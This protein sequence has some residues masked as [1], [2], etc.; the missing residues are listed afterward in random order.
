MRKTLLVLLAL[1]VVGA[2]PA[3]SAHADSPGQEVAYGAG[4]VFGT[5]LYAPFKTTFCVVGA[6]TSGLA[7]PFSGPHGSARMVTAA[8]AGTWAITPAVLKGQQ[9]VRFAGEPRPATFEPRST[10]LEPWP[11]TSEPQPTTSELQPA[12]SE[13]RPAT[14][15]P[16]PIT[17]EP[18]P[19]TSEPRS[20]IKDWHDVDENSPSAAPR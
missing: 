14:S 4:S 9:P 13:P 16:Q 17:S 20:T 6:V 3:S 18:Q 7:L 5:L 12:A 19:T 10:T 11:T 15:E 8:C 2:L 1:S